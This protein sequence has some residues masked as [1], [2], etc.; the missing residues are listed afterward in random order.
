MAGET[1]EEEVQRWERLSQIL[2]PLHIVKSKG[3]IE[4][5]WYEG[6]KLGQSQL[7]V[8]SWNL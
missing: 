7:E 1:N 3:G 2:E 4:V 8:S 6:R 5:A